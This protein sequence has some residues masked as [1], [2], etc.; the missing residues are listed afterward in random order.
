MPGINQTGKPST[1]DLYLGRGAV[2]LALI[3]AV[4]G[5]P[6]AFRHVGN[7][8]AFSLNLETEKLEHQSSRSGVRAI[9]REIILSQ[10]IGISLT[11]D[12]AT[13]FENL[14]L[15]LS[16]TATAGVANPA[17][18]ASIT[19]RLITDDAQPGRSYDLVDAS[20]NRLYDIDSTGSP[21]AFSAASGGELISHAT[22]LGS[23]TVRSP[24]TDYELDPVW[25]T[26]FVV[27]GGAIAAGDSIWFSYTG[28][29]S[30]KSF[31]MVNMLTQSKQSAFLRFKGINPANS[32]RGILV[33]LHSVSL[34]AD[35]EMPLIGEEFA[36]LTLTGVAERNETG[37]PNVPVGQI[38]YHGDAIAS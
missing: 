38:I 29:S 17:T 16:G 24:G 15:F 1:S 22:T 3:D 20:G 12:E 36:E 37:F 32:D 5:K 7:A 34:S 26:F 14:A 35:G 23:A 30:E 13:N 18:S 11:M 8:T 21:K 25:G 19:D 10:K 9:D 33:D 27:P 6:Y 28:V 31:D 2:E 4:T